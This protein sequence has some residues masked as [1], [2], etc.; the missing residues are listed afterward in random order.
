MRL[1]FNVNMNTEPLECFV[2][3]LARKHT[4][5]QQDFTIT[6]LTSHRE[7]LP[8]YLAARRTRPDI[9]ISPGI[10]RASHVIMARGASDFKRSQG[11]DGRSQNIGNISEQ[12]AHVK[13]TV[14]QILAC[15]EARSEKVASR[16]LG[17]ALCV[18]NSLHKNKKRIISL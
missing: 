9:E 1:R 7:Q 11:K 6:A 2:S 10:P 17:V 15:R 16:F 18:S 13:F 14:D 5:E 4:E 3:G 12:P 8:G